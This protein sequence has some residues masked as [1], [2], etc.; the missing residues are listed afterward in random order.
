M[1]HRKRD[2]GTR[3]AA[4]EPEALVPAQSVT[5]VVDSCT[6]FGARREVQIHHKGAVYT[7]RKTRQGKLILNK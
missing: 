4:V 2:S 6:L 5:R 3:P 7:L 1:Q